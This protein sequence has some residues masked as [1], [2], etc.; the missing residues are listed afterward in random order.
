MMKRTGG[1]SGRGFLVAIEGIDGSGK[2]TLIANVAKGMEELDIPHLCSREPTTEKFGILLRQS[3]QNRYSPLE[4]Y[5]LFQLDRAQHG[6]EKITPA[7]HEG[8]VVL[9][10]RFFYSTLVYQASIL[11]GP[12]GETLEQKRDRI[13][14]ESFA[15]VPNPELVFFLDLDPEEASSRIHSSRGKLDAFEAKLGECR[16]AYLELAA[17]PLVATRAKVLDA[18]EDPD[19]LA[20]GVLDQITVRV[21]QR[22][23]VRG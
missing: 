3:R 17:H 20:K 1:P 6:R 18:T 23:L 16:R 15:I 7:I 2:S 13:F 12:V 22:G 14:F 11:P 4:E 9:V 5:W 21:C 19:E 10:D 8:K